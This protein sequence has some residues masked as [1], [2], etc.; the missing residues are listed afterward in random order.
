M[1]KVIMFMTEAGCFAGCKERNEAFRKNV[2][3]FVKYHFEGDY[4]FKE[5]VCGEYC[6]DSDY[7][8]IF[9]SNPDCEV[10]FALDCCSE[11]QWQATKRGKL[12]FRWSGSSSEEKILLVKEVE[13][14]ADAGIRMY[15]IRGC[16][17]KF[18][19]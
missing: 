10:V 2:R 8:S 19:M 11:A 4:T 6:V 16:K 1:A 17:L 13:K 5:Y 18:R 15:S 7:E 3:D 12:T 14:N 9:T